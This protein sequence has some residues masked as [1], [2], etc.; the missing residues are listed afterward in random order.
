MTSQPIDLDDELPLLTE[1]ADG[2]TATELPLLTEIITT[3][4]TAPA[5]EEASA[6]VIVEVLSPAAP[7]VLSAEQIE[8][9]LQHLENHLETVLTDK[10]NTQLAQLQKL[11]VDLAVTEFMAE[12]PQLVRDA[13]K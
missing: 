1:V 11:A 2:E 10:L 6:P 4:R 7:P 9:L 8:Q 12:L 5:D 13:L 3:T